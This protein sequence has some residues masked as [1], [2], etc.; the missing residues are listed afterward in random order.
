VELAEYAALDAVGLAAALHRRELSAAEVLDA[1]RRALVAVQPRLN[2]LADGPWERPLEYAADGPFAGV[3]ML[4]K[5]IGCPVGGLPIR[6]GSRA[7]GAGLVLEDDSWLW[8]LFRGAGFAALGVAP[9]PE[10]A[11][12]VLTESVRHGVTRNPWDPARSPGG[13]SGAGAAAVAAGAVPM[14]HANDGGGSI[15][16]PAAHT[17][18]VGLKPSRGR[19]TSGPG[20]GESLQG[21]ATNFVLTRTVRDAAALLDVLAVPQPGDRYLVQRPERPWSQEL[22]REPRRLRIAVRTQGSGGTPVDPEVVTAVRGVAA[23][24]A[25]LGHEVVEAAPAVDWEAY[26]QALVVVWAAGVA[27]DAAWITQATGGQ[28]RPELYETAIAASIRHGRTLD[29]LDLAG[30]LDVANRVSRAVGIFLGTYD[31]ILTPSVNTLP[32]PV[33]TVD[34]DDPLFAELEPA[35]A[36]REWVDRTFALCSFTSLY[37][38]TGTPAISLPLGW[39]EEGLPIGVQFATRMGDE[40]TLFR[41]AAQLEELMPWSQ[42]RPRVHVSALSD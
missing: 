27:E 6:L 19:I 10:L 41:L 38:V 3:P 34:A 40:A 1:A 35:R 23:T 14:A 9:V 18:T 31:L 32:V 13:S 36:V 8:R 30:A 15:R 16:I 33:G 39:S 11:F 12:H 21:F 17:A 28:F 25:G 2:V 42:R 5:D 24:L 37:N 26:A 29:V 7:T 20:R 4:I 22:G